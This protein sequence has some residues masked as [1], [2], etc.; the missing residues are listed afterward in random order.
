MRVH[1]IITA[2]HR[3]SLMR[4]MRDA[5]VNSPTV[6]GAW[7]LEARRPS[8]RP[9]CGRPDLMPRVIEA[10]QEHGLRHLLFGSTPEVLERLQASLRERFPEALIV[11]AISPP[12]RSLSS[13]EEAELTAEI[14]A[15]RPHIVWV[16]L[17]LAQAGRVDVEQPHGVP[18]ALALGVGAAFEFLAVPSPGLPMDAASGSRM[19]A[20]SATRAAAIGR[21]LSQDQHRVPRRAVAVMARRYTRSAVHAL[22]RPF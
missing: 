4:A 11:G 17:G 21:A 9:P 19:A 15:A 13:Q 2:Q 3:E 7:L 5:W 16:G 1:G 8:R 18:P 22:R 12:F 14:N 6:R 10:G 20:P